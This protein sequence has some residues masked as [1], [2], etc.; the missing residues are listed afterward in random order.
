ME[1]IA[2]E[3]LRVGDVVLVRSGAR[4]PA[5]GEIVE[6]SAELDE[7]MITGESKPVAKDVGDRV[8]AGTVSTDSA[9]RVRVDAVG[10]DT[11]LAGI[12]RL[13]SEAQESRSRAQ[14]LADR[15]AALLFYVATG[16]AVIT[17]IVWL[18]LGE[19]DEA[20]TR[21]VTVLVI[22]CPHTLGLAI[23]LTTSIS[24]A[25]AATN[26][27]LVKDRLALEESRTVQAFLFDKTG[28]LTKGQHTVVG[29]AGA[30]GVSEDEVLRLS[31]GVESDSEHPTG[32]GNRH[33]RTRPRKDARRRPGSD[34]SP[35]EASKPPST[36]R[37]TPSVVRRC[38][39]SGPSPSLPSWPTG[40]SSG[41]SGAP[42][43]CTWLAATRSSVGSRSRTRSGPRPGTPS[44]NSRRWAGRW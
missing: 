7:S 28:T 8:V 43:S 5:D 14:V 13:V 44:P 31:G 40:S 33:G 29:V 42:R 20:V 27:I 30:G 17:G 25:M 26:G 1:T 4:V 9:I 23:P 37:P 18:A 12:Q 6:G 34:P 35:A 32:P 24:S 3:D 11:A 41:R 19:T 10:E 2:L 38:S 15:A 39:A 21:V 36:A 22:S 16:A